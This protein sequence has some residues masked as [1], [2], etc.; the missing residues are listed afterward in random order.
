MT[1][2][3]SVPLF[4]CF[5]MFLCFSVPLFQCSFVSVFFFFVSVFLCFS[6]FS[7]VPLFQCSFVSVFQCFYMQ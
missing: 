6:V 7:V 4:Q 3:D 2:F 1:A 5:Y